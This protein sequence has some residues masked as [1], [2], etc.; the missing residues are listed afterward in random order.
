MWKTPSPRLSSPAERFAPRRGCVPVVVGAALLIETASGEPSQLCGLSLWVLVCSGPVRHA[1][2]SSRL[3]GL[4]E[5]CVQG[6]SEMEERLKMMHKRHAALAQQL[7]ARTKE[8]N[9]A[10]KRA[11]ALKQ[12]HSPV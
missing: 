6:L 4:V 12:V 10:V 3:G 11:G 1:P 8:R 7:D 9:E 5:G 2:C